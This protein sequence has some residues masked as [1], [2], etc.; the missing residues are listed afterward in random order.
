MTEVEEDLA[1]LKISGDAE[2]GRKVSGKCTI[3]EMDIEEGRQAFR[4]DVE[5]ILLKKIGQPKVLTKQSEKAFECS[6]ETLVWR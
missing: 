6:K 3:F 4:Y 5:I 1:K 2:A